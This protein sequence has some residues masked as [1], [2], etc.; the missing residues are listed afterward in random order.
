MHTIHAEYPIPGVRVEHAVVTSDDG[1]T[2]HCDVFLNGRLVGSVWDQWVD[3]GWWWAWLWQEDTDPTPRGSSEPDYPD[4][5]A[6]IE[7]LLQHPA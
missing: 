3:H 1:R 7:A 2:R 4:R 6:A 5:D